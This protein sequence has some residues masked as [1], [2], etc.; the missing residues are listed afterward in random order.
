MMDEKVLESAIEKYMV[1]RCRESGVFI[2]KN[3]GMRGIPDRLLIYNGRHIFVE[4]KRPG[5]K[6]RPLQIALI[7]K[8]RDHGAE[9][10]IVDTKDKVDEVIRDICDENKI[11]R[12]NR[13]KIL[14]IAED[15]IAG[16]YGS[17]SEE[18]RNN[19]EKT[20]Q[21]ADIVFDFV[22]RLIKY[23]EEHKDE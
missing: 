21:Q 22:D 18:I 19:I 15:V 7:E 20:G 16:R 3:T 11:I 6:P 13:K 10:L 17:T 9:V 2:L 5:G 23:N 8:L 4:L 12:P 14:T 1:K